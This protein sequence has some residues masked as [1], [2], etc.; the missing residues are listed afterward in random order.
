MTPAAKLSVEKFVF[1]EIACN[2]KLPLDTHNPRDL[3]S[4]EKNLAIPFIKTNMMDAVSGSM[5]GISPEKRSV[6]YAMAEA[7]RE[8]SPNGMAFT[9][10]NTALVSR[11]LVNF[12]KAA[13]LVYSGKLDRTTAFNTLFPDLKSLGPLHTRSRRTPIRAPSTS[14]TPIPRA[15]R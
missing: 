1:E 6:I 15:A 8:K 12:P 14:S 13:E 3:F 7:L 4:E 9:T 11:T 10:F 5:A 2:P